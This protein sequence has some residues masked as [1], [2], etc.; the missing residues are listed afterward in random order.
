MVSTATGTPAEIE[1]GRYGLADLSQVPLLEAQEH[2][3]RR[4]QET[5]QGSAIW[6]GRKGV[7]MREV[8]GLERITDR[9]TILGIDATT[10]L[11]LIVRLQG[12]VP[13]MPPGASEL[14]V[15]NEALLALRYPEEIMTQPLPGYALV[16]IL[17]PPHVHHPSVGQTDGL[18]P[19]CLAAALPRGLPLR[20]AIVSS[21]AALACQTINVDERSAAGLMNASAGLWFQQNMDKLPLSAVPFLAPLSTDRQLEAT[22]SHS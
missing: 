16:G 17:E 19:L 15:E 13:C 4:M 3:L 9:M 10:D 7:E 6:R 2:A 8:L 1:H 20:E 18:Q 11:R 22:R 14:V 21:Y 5:S 12:P